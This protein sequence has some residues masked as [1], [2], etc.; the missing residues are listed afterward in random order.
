MYGISGRA[1]NHT[2]KTMNEFTRCVGCGALIIL[3][4]GMC[5]LCHTANNLENI[6]RIY[7]ERQ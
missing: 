4:Q 3:E 1:L 5:P 7:L 2:S 6:T